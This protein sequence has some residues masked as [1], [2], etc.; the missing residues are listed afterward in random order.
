MK[1]LGVR[2]LNLDFEDKFPVRSS[3]NEIILKFI[4]AVQIDIHVHAPVLL[5][6]YHLH[7][8][9]AW[10]SFHASGI[11]ANHAERES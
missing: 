2:E 10:F 8:F 3:I 1:E 4:A 9:H 7:S 6:A 5:R 11:V